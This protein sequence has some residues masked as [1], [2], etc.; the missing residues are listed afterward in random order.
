MRR[1]E[2]IV[3]LGP[4]VWPLDAR[5]QK[6][7]K[8]QIIKFLGA[9]RPCSAALAVK[10]QAKEEWSRGVPYAALVRRGDGRAFHRARRQRPA[11]TCV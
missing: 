10:R 6:T 1:G 8:V 7:R 4:L 3:L 11:L 9:N 2:F 5:T